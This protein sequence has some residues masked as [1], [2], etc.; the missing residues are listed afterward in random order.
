MPHRVC[1]ECGA[2]FGNHE[3]HLKFHEDIDELVDWAQSVSELFK[4][5]SSNVEGSIRGLLERV[6][7]GNITPREA[8]ERSG[9]E[10]QEKPDKE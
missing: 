7:D 3:K 4:P 8:M 5:N 1:N 10:L 2:M 9:I 6:S